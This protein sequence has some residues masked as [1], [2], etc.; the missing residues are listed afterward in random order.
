M[1][2]SP[3]GRFAR[4][5]VIARPGL[6]DEQ[7]AAHQTINDALRR[8]AGI[9]VDDTPPP[10]LGGMNAELRGLFPADQNPPVPSKSVATSL[11]GRQQAV[12]A[13]LFRDVPG[14][15]DGDQ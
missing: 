12:A 4:R 5:T 13:R 1:F 10:P 14:R 2:R 6:T 3:S 7:A 15:K 8:A 11:T 9:S